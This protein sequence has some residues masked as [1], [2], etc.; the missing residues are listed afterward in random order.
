MWRSSATAA[1]GCRKGRRKEAGRDVVV[2]ADARKEQKAELQR[3][4]GR[5]PVD[6]PPGNTPRGERDVT[7]WGAELS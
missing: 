2:E 5:Q 4:R 3:L 7:V 1:V 6:S